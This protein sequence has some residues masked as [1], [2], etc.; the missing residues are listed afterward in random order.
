MGIILDIKILVLSSYQ[1][2]KGKWEMV[3]FRAIPAASSEKRKYN[4]KSLTRSHG[5]LCC[6][7]DSRE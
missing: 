4:S 2:M 5:H 3:Q 7:L 1:G 6:T